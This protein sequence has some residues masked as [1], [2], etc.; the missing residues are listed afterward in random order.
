MTIKVGFS[1]SLY[2]NIITKLQMWLFKINYSHV[3]IRIKYQDFDLVLHATGIGLHLVSFKT[4][5]LK[6]TPVKEFIVS[7]PHVDYRP[8]LHY[9][10]DTTGKKYG[11]KEMLGAG[12]AKIFRLKKNPFKSADNTFCSEAVGVVMEKFFGFDIEGD[13]SLWAPKD[14]HDYLETR[15]V[16][17]SEVED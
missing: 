16:D 8:F 9:A 1:H 5:A 13:S 17:A 12:L 4:F 14:I 3:Y 2:P 15:A 7:S 11:T 6:R 10:F